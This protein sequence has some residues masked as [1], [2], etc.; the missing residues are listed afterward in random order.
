MFGFVT[1]KCHP[2]GAVDK[3][4]PTHGWLKK[5]DWGEERKELGIW[6][7]AVFEDLEGPENVRGWCGKRWDSQSYPFPHPSLS[8]RPTLLL[9]PH[10]M[11]VGGQTLA[12]W[13]PGP[14]LPA[15]GLGMA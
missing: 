5:A 1:R 11:S 6:E 15:V 9:P 3:E 10:S 2:A 8:G 14:L 7:E 13:M 4:T 12:S